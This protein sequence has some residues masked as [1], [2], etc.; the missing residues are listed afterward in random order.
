MNDVIHEI[1]RLFVASFVFFG[2]LG[3]ALIVAASL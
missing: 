3:A 2:T 1:G